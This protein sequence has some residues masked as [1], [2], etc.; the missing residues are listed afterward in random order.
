MEPDNANGG[1]KA[2]SIVF[3]NVVELIRL[4]MERAQPKSKAVYILDDTEGT[5]SYARFLAGAK[6]EVVGRHN[7]STIELPE[8]SLESLN[9]KNSRNLRH[10]ILLHEKTVIL[11]SRNLKFL[12]A[13]VDDTYA[14]NFTFVVMSGALMLLACGFLAAWFLTRMRRARRV[15]EVMAAAKA[16]KAA[17]L[18]ESAKQTAAAE[19]ELNDY[20][21]HEVRNPLSA[22]L[23]AFSF[24]S[25]AVNKR[26]PLTTDEECKVVREDMKVMSNSLHFVND[27]LRNVRWIIC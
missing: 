5:S 16:E 8:D 19:R 12:V 17:L 10:Y 23:T 6:L 9:V 3:F 21:A 13:T 20:V 27:L 2:V 7:V 4:A 11:G 18:V 24:V 26:R 22:A 1:P 25:A 15:S 14:A